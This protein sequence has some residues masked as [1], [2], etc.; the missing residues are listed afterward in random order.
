MGCPPCR[1][2]PTHPEAQPRRAAVFARP[3]ALGLAREGARRQGTARSSVAALP[4][5]RRASSGGRLTAA[6]GCQIVLGQALAQHLH[7]VD[8]LAAL[9]AGRPTRADDILPLRVLSLGELADGRMGV[10]Q[11][12]GIPA[13]LREP[14]HAAAHALD[15]GRLDSG[16]LRQPDLPSRAY[17]LGEAQGLSA[18]QAAFGEDRDEVFPFAHHEG[19]DAG[20]ARALHHGGEQPV[21]FARGLARREEVA[22]LEVE[23]VDAVARHETAAMGWLE[24][25]SCKTLGTTRT[26]RRGVRATER[27]R[28]SVSLGQI[29]RRRLGAR[30]RACAE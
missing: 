18:Q 4:R 30:S 19:R 9:V 13:L 7:Q 17:L 26:L 14:A 22:A 5:G 20:A 1:S 6:L 8:D 12:G 29:G 28:W 27:H 3:A 21:G 2:A 23:G 15:E 24:Q 16:G 25:F 10:A 11:L